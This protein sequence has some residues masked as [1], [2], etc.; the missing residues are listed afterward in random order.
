MILLPYQRE[1]RTGQLHVCD[2][3]EQLSPLACLSRSEAGRHGLFT[4]HLLQDLTDKDDEV[5]M[6]GVYI[7]SVPE[8]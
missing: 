4:R 3:A 8:A 7:H 5:R 1:A 6:I 2:A